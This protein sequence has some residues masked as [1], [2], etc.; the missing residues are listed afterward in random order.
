MTRTRLHAHAAQLG[1][2]FEN[3]RIE[4]TTQGRAGVN[5][6]SV[7]ARHGSVHGTDIG[8]NLRRFLEN[9]SVID[10]NV[11]EHPFAPSEFG[12]TWQYD[13]DELGDAMT[14]RSP[15]QNPPSPTADLLNSIPV[16]IPRE[17]SEESPLATR[18]AGGPNNLLATTEQPSDRALTSGNESQ[19]MS[20]SQSSTSDKQTDTS[21][22]LAQ[23]LFDLIK[24]D[25]VIDLQRLVKSHYGS[26]PNSVKFNGWTPLEWAIKH[27]KAEAA[28]K[29][30]RMGATV[31]AAAIGPDCSRVPIQLAVEANRAELIHLL[32]QNG[33]DVN[34]HDAVDGFTALHIAAKY[35]VFD[36]PAAPVN[37]LLILI[38]IGIE[39]KVDYE[40]RDNLGWTPLMHA[41]KSGHPK[42][43]SFFL[44]H[45]P[46][47]PARNESG[48]T[49]LHIAVANDRQQTVELLLEH[50]GVKNWLNFGA[51]EHHELPLHL[52]TNRAQPNLQIVHLLLESGAN[53]DGID[54]RGNTAIMNSVIHRSLSMIKLFLE[55]GANL[56][57]PANVTSSV[58]YGCLHL[59]A[60]SGNEEILNILLDGG[61][62]LEAESKD[63]RTPFILAVEESQKASAQTLL[64]RGA[65][66]L[67]SSSGASAL[68]LAVS[69]TDCEMICLILQPNVQA[70]QYGGLLE[71]QMNGNSVSLEDTMRRTLALLVACSLGHKEAVNLLI[72]NGADVNA[73]TETGLTPLLSASAGDHIEVMQLLIKQGANTS[74]V[75]RHDGFRPLQIAASESFSTEVVEL[76]LLQ[77]VEIDVKD[78]AG[79][80]FLALL[81]RLGR[82]EILKAVLKHGADVNIKN[83]STQKTALM[84]AAE[85]G[86]L[87]IVKLLLEHGA[88]AAELNSDGMS[89]MDLARSNGHFDV[90]TEILKKHMEG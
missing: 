58:G 5:Q 70:A 51:G 18:S 57:K 89:A 83:S 60:L 67:S 68:G 2:Q 62:E 23:K 41:A 42:T 15:V 27:N 85:G 52:A 46:W 45:I 13:D 36:K 87:E 77:K 35:G 50:P 69:N 80:S 39:Q 40:A 88:L 47:L 66:P 63:G 26:D 4:V 64:D 3:L 20:G 1:G 76:L 30:I 72:V 31:E 9:E 11:D 82:H 19:T 33:A 28:R 12:G 25:S 34:S 56:E 48:W 73:S 44:K 22:V 79:E 54:G 65:N 84:E 38:D 61:A 49:A 75:R 81:S 59:A 78:E 29:L 43:V 53:L 90:S 74:S 10:P 6:A 21:A 86:N 24:D 17:S 14:V 16:Y 37:S 55:N 32:I 8:F 71:V 7:I